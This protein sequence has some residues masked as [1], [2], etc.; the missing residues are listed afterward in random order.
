[1]AADILPGNYASNLENARALDL[2]EPAILFIINEIQGEEFFGSGFVINHDGLALTCE[3]VI[4]GAESLKAR[5]RFNQQEY[6]TTCQVLKTVP[7]LDLALMRLE[8]NNLPCSVLASLERPPKKG[9]AVG[10]LGYPLGKQLSQDANY[11]EGSIT[12]IQSDEYGELV[13]CSAQAYPGNSGGPVFCRESGEVLGLLHGALAREEAR[14]INF[15][16]PIKY[17]WEHFFKK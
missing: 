13:Q 17:V 8:Q 4:R 12:S 11:T 9:Q 5:L 3:H 2:V 16:R 6:W 14:G 1:L 10:L 15:F 7:G